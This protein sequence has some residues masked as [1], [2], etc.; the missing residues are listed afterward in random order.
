MSCP[1]LKWHIYIAYRERFDSDITISR[2]VTVLVFGDRSVQVVSRNALAATVNALV[3]VRGELPTA[4]ATL[5]DHDCAVE[6][7]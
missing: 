2:E 3:L 6:Q 7:N 4:A 1:P 5:T